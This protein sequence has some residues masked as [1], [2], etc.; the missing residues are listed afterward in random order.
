MSTLLS[1]APRPP[2]PEEQ[3]AVCGLLAL[4]GEGGTGLAGP[5]RWMPAAPRSAAG[6]QA[7]HYGMCVTAQKPGS[8]DAAMKGVPILRRGATFCVGPAPEGMEW[9][10]MVIFPSGLGLVSGRFTILW[11]TVASTDDRRETALCRGLGLTRRDGKTP[12]L[13]PVLLL[14]LAKPGSPPLT[15]K[16]AQYIYSFAHDTGG[17]IHMAVV[18]SILQTLRNRAASECRRAWVEANRKFTPISST[19]PTIP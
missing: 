2:S 7:W 18:E 10:H 3:S 6:R 4:S 8:P 9:R 14:P 13:G 1:I 15:F 16:S 11:Y 19:T 17:E 12:I 5:T